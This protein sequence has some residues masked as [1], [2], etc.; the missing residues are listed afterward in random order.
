MYGPLLQQDRPDRLWWVLADAH[1][2]NLRCQVGS[3]SFDGQ[4]FRSPIL[5]VA[6]VS[7][8]SDCKVAKRSSLFCSRRRVSDD[9]TLAQRFDVAAVYL[10]EL[11]ALVVRARIAQ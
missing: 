6:I 9:V 4:T 1:R 8:N 7:W 2:R 5:K 3:I 11:E 10:A